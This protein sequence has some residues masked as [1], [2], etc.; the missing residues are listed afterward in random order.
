MSEGIFLWK[1][2]V[3]KISAVIANCESME[4]FYLL[5]RIFVLFN[6]FFFFN[7]EQVLLF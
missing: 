4:D 7:N 6:F 2:T 5:Q 1:L 3:I